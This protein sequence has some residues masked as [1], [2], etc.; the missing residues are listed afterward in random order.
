MNHPGE[1]AV[2][3]TLAAPSVALITNAQREHQ[4]FM[5]SVEAVAQE[6]GA[7]IEALP[8]DGIAVFPGDD[9]HCGVWEAQAGARRI[10]RFGLQPGLD[11]YAENIEAAPQGTRCQV[12]TPAG[13]ADLM[14][15][16]P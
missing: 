14:L 11:I 4:E 15:P 6:N 16:V 3:A 12:V 10:L 8:D 5:H 1:I 13:S 7:S 2:L 9:P